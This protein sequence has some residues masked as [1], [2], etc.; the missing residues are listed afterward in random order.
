MTSLQ[1]AAPPSS[2][3]PWPWIKCLR[4]MTDPL[5]DNNQ[6]YNTSTQDDVE[7]PVEILPWLYLSDR[8]NAMNLQKLKR[9][10]ITHILSVC[11]MAPREL[12]DWKE[13]LEGTNI[14][15]KQINCDDT[16]GYDMIGKHWETCLELLRDVRRQHKI[17]DSKKRVVVHCVAGVNRSGLIV[18]AASMILE[19]NLLLE[20]AKDCLQKRGGLLLWNRS[21][22]KQL[23]GLAQ[24]H[25]LLGP[26]PEGYDLQPLIDTLPPPPPAHYHCIEFATAKQTLTQHLLT[27]LTFEDSITKQQR[28][29]NK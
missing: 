10:N 27:H 11:G 2:S 4:D 6:K 25:N 23:C 14:I 16:E 28:Q 9:H 24:R 29:S 22:Q 13:R 12:N 1:E 21:F 3:Q 8:K 15:H 5:S 26:Q 20:V 7:L 19:Q 17:Q 18:C